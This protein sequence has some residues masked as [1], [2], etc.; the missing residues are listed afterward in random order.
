MEGGVLDKAGKVLPGSPTISRTS[1]GIFDS[2]REHGNHQDAKVG[3]PYI[4]TLIQCSP[5]CKSLD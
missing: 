4:P 1:S 3:T 2:D 5:K